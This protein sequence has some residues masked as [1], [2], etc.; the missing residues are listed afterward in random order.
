MV[1]QQERDSGGGRGRRKRKAGG[2][3]AG[4]IFVI[5]SAGGHDIDEYTNSTNSRDEKR[6]RCKVAW[7][8]WTPAGETGVG[9]D[10][11]G[12]G[13]LVTTLDDAAAHRAGWNR[14]RRA[15]M[16][17]HLGDG[18]DCDATSCGGSCT[19]YGGGQKHSTM[20]RR[21]AGK[22]AVKAAGRG[23]AGLWETPMLRACGQSGS[24]PASCGR[25]GGAGSDQ[26]RKRGMRGRRQTRSTGGLGLA[27]ATGNDTSQL[28]GG[29]RKG[30]HMPIISHGLGCPK[31]VYLKLGGSTDAPPPEKHPISNEKDFPDA[32]DNSGSRDQKD[33]L[34][35]REYDTESYDITPSAKLKGLDTAQKE[36]ALY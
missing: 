19:V 35:E 25:R 21:G 27:A 1:S 23:G 14:W 7:G 6:I 31:R 18:S 8:V 17:G 32:R 33:Y 16:R 13:R 34:Y 12:T 22:S 5:V 15:V 28:C 29:K 4:N 3:P 10:D 24:R 26:Q 36:I 11:M 9:T 2:L 20:A 30:R